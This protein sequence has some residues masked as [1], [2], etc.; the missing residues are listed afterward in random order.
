VPRG[1]L[2]LAPRHRQP[3]LAHLPDPTSVLES[4]RTALA[5]D[6]VVL[7]EH[8]E[9]IDSPPGALRTYDEVAA[10]VVRRGGGV[11]YAGAALAGFGGRRIHVTVPAATAAT[12]YLFNVRRWLR[13]GGDRRAGQRLVELR[14]DLEA[15]ARHDDGRTTSWIVRQLALPA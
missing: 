11:M 10:M 14:H 8:L 12:I 4:W 5:P 3:L 6:G 9:G 7:V 1:D 15:I 13:D 2:D